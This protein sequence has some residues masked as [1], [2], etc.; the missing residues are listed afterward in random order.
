MNIRTIPLVGAI[1]MGLLAVTLR[2]RSAAAGGVFADALLRAARRDLDRG[3]REDIG[4]NDGER[5]RQYFAGSGITPPANWC[6][7]AVTTWI[8]EA[9]LEAGVA[10]PPIA[11]SMQAKKIRDQIEEAGQWFDADAVRADPSIVRPG[12]IAVWDRSQ[13]GKPETSWFGHVG[14]IVGPSGGGTFPTIEGN[15]GQMGDRVAAVDRRLDD[16]KLLGVGAAW[17]VHG[18][19]IISSRRARRRMMAPPEEGGG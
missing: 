9:A 7:A 15:S 1:I 3:I 10:P 2:A 12:M 6:A 18:V 17:P 19:K 16:P 13:P 4:K 11:G 14:V 5:I 8:R